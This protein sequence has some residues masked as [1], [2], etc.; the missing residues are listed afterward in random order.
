MYIWLDN[1]KL[2]YGG[3]KHEMQRLLDDAEK[4]SGIHYDIDNY[5]DII[6]AIHVIQEEMGITGTT[7]QEAE[8]TISG[9]LNTLKASWDNFVVE[10]GKGDGDIGGKFDEVMKSLDTV[11]GNL[12]PVL[13]SI[14]KNIGELIVHIVEE[15]GKHGPEIL[16]AGVDLLGELAK[17]I[18][19]ATAK[20]VEALPDLI[21]G[22][23]EWFATKFPD[24][25]AAGVELLSQLFV[26]L[27]AILLNLNKAIEDISNALVKEFEKY[28]PTIKQAGLDLLTK[29]G[30]GIVSGIQWIVWKAQ[31]VAEKIINGI[32]EFF[33]I[34]TGGKSK[35]K[36]AGEEVANDMI[37]GLVDSIGEGIG[38]IVDKAKEIYDGITGV[39][40]D[41]LGY[42]SGAFSEAWDK[43]WNA[44][45]ELISGVFGGIVE[46]V[47]EKFNGIVDKVKEP[48]NAVIGFLNMLIDKVEQAINWIIGGFNS[49]SVTI[50]DWV[51]GVGGNTFGVNIPAATFGRIDLLAEGGVVKEGGKAI[52][53]EYEPETLQVINGQ[54]IV[55]PMHTGRFGNEKGVTINVYP[56][57]GQSEEEIARMVQRQFTTW[58][59]QE[60][61]AFA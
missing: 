41:L 52:V 53:G 18:P 22:I 44:V 26:N 38:S 12:G 21:T 47:G 31:E 27:E 42:I 5:A 13:E 56:Q 35:S 17:S 3:T 11:V 59:S 55:T 23:I 48:I 29:L 46:T 51:P 10:L 49:I 15:I 8:E 57:K 36:E 37:N 45:S 1:L 24:I 40:G 14:T 61:A 32:K 34:G 58:Q 43:A 39:L 60:E 16:Q 30:D 9:S 2:G 19:D 25:A 33:G 20:I 54:A 4:L 28:W 7:A 6:Q 50:P